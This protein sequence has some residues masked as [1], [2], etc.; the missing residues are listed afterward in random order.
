MTKIKLY[1]VR[2]GKTI[3]NSLDYIQG[4]S[5]SPLIKSGIDELKH[6]A[7]NF[8]NRGWDV[9]RCYHS[10]LKRTKDTLDILLEY[11]PNIDRF[12]IPI[13][14]ADGIQEWSFG[15]Y[16]GFNKAFWLFKNLLP[17]ISGKND[18]SELSCE[19]IANTFSKIDTLKM[20]EN[21][22][23]LKSRII[24]GFTDIAEDCIKSNSNAIVVS[25]GM[26]MLALYYILTGETIYPGSLKNGALLELSFDGSNFT[27]ESLEKEI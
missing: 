9:R 15:S 12:N 14:E 26:T 19:E 16:E 3:F 21:W 17:N 6:I 27:I 24:K 4:D 13:I 25:H 2:H 11:M 8:Y 1:V 10:N 20:S 5:N 22:D 23:S 18:L 7:I